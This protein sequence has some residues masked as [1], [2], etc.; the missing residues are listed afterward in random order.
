M[1]TMQGHRKKRTTLYD[2][3][4]VPE[5]LATAYKQA[6]H[7][8]HAWIN[9]RW[10]ATKHWTHY[11]LN[12]EN[13]NDMKNSNFTDDRTTEQKITHPYLVVMTDKLSTRILGLPCYCAWACEG[14]HLNKIMN[15]VSNR[16]D[17]M[18]VRQCNAT[19]RPKG[20]CNARIFVVTDE[21][22]HV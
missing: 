2:L 21:H 18:R 16:T 14:R 6:R 10:F 19:W 1:M 4:R 22:A 7:F 12:I 5:S 11:F 17:A 13:T 3:Q 20:Y 9:S 15:W 8:V